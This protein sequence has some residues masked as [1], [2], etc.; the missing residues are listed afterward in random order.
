LIVLIIHLLKY[1]LQSGRR[2]RSWIA[3]IGEQR[4]ILPIVDDSPGLREFHASILGACYAKARSAA[5]DE[6]GITERRF[7]E[8]CPFPIAA[9]LDRRWLPGRPLPGDR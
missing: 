9:V 8:R 4:R 1:Q 7:P 6:T 2:S 3:T 5:T